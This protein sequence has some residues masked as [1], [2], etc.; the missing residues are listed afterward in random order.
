MFPF[1]ENLV[2]AINAYYNSV[3]TGR[4]SLDTIFHLMYLG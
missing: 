1:F 4:H 3:A 2:S